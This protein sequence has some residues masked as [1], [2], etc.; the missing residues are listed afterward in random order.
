MP[1]RRLR[2]SR[3]SDFFS[4]RFPLASFLFTNRVMRNVQRDFLYKIIETS[5]SAATPL[6]YSN[7]HPA[8]QSHPILSFSSTPPCIKETGAL[9]GILGGKLG[10]QLGWIFYKVRRQLVNTVLL[11]L[12]WHL[13]RIPLGL[14]SEMEL[15]HKPFERPYSEITETK[16]QY[17]K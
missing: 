8:A 16:R 9:C 17:T 10:S 5:R 7:R 14:G 4:S 1:N 6:R 2:R 3:G 12:V 15:F 13:P 11:T